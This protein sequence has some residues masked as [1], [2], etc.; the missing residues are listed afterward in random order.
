MNKGFLYVFLCFIL[1][2]AAGAANR[3]VT[4]VVLAGDDNQPLVG[5][6]IQVP[7]DELKKAGIS[8]NT[9]GTI[10]DVNGNFSISVPDEVRRLVF[11]YIGYQEESLLLQ[12]GRN[13]YRIVLQSGTHM[14]ADVVVT[15]YQTVERRRLTAAVSKIDVSEAVIGAAKSIDQALAGQIAGVSVTNTTGSPGAP[16]RIRIRGTASLNGT[17]D[18][19]WVM[20][21]MPLEGTD[22]PR[23]SSSNDND[24][25]YKPE[26]Y[27]KHHDTQGCCSYSDLR[28]TCCQRRDCDYDQTRTQRKTRDQLQYPAYVYAEP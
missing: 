6:S 24:C 7:S 21:G 16:A 19:L 14:L 27:R 11:T 12:D 8:S 23:I 18:P 3:V 26:R 4:G 2:I 5:V 9:L 13:D 20:D 28:R 22:I 17:Q 10:T 15:G 25:R 1:S